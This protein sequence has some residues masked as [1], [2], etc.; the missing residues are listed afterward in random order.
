MYVIKAHFHE[1][2]YWS[3]KLRGYIS[4]QKNATRYESKQIALRTIQGWQGVCNAARPVRLV[5][6]KFCKKAYAVP[7]PGTVF[8]GICGD[9][10]M[11]VEPR[12]DDNSNVHVVCA[13]GDRTDYSTL[14][15]WWKDIANS[16]STLVWDHKEKNQV[17]SL[18]DFFVQYDMLWLL[19]EALVQREKDEANNV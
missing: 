16:R 15:L 10:Y 8:L 3:D 11:I 12:R 19:D 1:H 6:K 14:E 17:R 9:P 5:S 2:L 13:S 7:A 4:I 18:H